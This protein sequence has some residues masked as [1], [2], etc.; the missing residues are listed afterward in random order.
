MRLPHL[1]HSSHRISNAREAAPLDWYRG[2]WTM[3]MPRK[4][5]H[6][7]T[8]SPSQL[9]AYNYRHQLGTTVHSFRRHPPPSLLSAPTALQLADVCLQVSGNDTPLPLLIFEQPS[10]C[11]GGDW[12]SRRRWDFGRIPAGHDSGFMGVGC[13]SVSTTLPA[14]SHSC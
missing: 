6:P 9:P 11:K 3:P 13:T 2:R 10:L 8:Y 14:T 5:E 7:S 1:S 12:R 4:D